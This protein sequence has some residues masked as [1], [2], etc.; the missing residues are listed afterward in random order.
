VQ[1][2]AI[3][4]ENIA[5]YNWCVSDP[6]YVNFEQAQGLKTCKIL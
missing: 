4:G 1:Y 2:F 3:W 6:F 5:K